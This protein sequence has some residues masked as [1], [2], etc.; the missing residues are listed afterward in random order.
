MQLHRASRFGAQCLGV[1]VSICFSSAR[2][3]GANIHDAS[4]PGASVHQH[5]PGEWPLDSCPPVESVQCADV[6]GKRKAAVYLVGI[7]HRAILNSTMQH[8]LR[9]LV[10]DGFA[11]H[12]YVSLIFD[13][14]GTGNWFA[15]TRSIGR[16]DPSIEHLSRRELQLHV[17]D[18]VQ[19]TGACLVCAEVPQ[20]PQTVPHIPVNAGQLSQFPPHRT[21]TGKRLLNMWL[22][23]E[24]MW[25]ATLQ[26]ERALGE[27]Y[28]FL[29]WVRDDALWV[30]D[31]A[32]P[33][34]LLR[35]PRAASTLWT[36]RCG[37]WGGLND[38]AGAP[39]GSEDAPH[40]PRV[41]P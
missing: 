40:G 2:A 6:S 30:A 37:A 3:W 21:R 5:L 16:E 13:A 34:V 25:N 17:H 11:V 29:M 20:R 27:R 14:S 28:E 1:I 4:L 35:T 31:M 39:G 19:A 10:D 7:K 26:R 18:L 38:K 22:R 24:R 9:R 15:S 23:R 36:R 41:G 33:S 32:R 12:V 8:V